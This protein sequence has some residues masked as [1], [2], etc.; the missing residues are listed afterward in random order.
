M[1]LKASLDTIMRTPPITASVSDA[2]SSVVESMV[3]Y[4]IGAII[5]M[6][7]GTPAGIITER[8]IVEKVV[9]A[10]KDPDKTR[11]QEIMSSPLISMEFDKSAADALKLMRDKRIRRLAVTRKG[12][13]TGIVTERRL[14]DS[15]V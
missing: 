1:G 6:S 2:V 7:D 10:R 14:L 11:A 4:S 3:S 9:K 13:L 15:L 5:V 12:R 8:D